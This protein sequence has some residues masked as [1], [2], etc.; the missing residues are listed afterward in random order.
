MITIE[1]LTDAT[2]YESFTQFKRNC[3]NSYPDVID[4][5]KTT[6][7]YYWRTSIAK[8]TCDLSP[9]ELNELVKEELNSNK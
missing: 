1:E 2:G 3:T 6:Y 7:E 4:D 9:Q 8:I 5:T